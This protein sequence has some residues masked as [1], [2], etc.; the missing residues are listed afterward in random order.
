VTQTYGLVV[1]GASVAAEALISRLRELGDEREVLVVDADPRMPY[2]RPPLSKSYLVSPADTA[3]DVEWPPGVPVTVARAV[4]L[5]PVQRQLTVEV[6]AS[7]TT[8][9]VG[10]EQL[11]IATGA[12]PIH[13]PFEPDGVLALRTALDADQ[14]RAGAGVG[15]RIGIIGAG[16]IG[17]ELATSLRQ[18]GSEVVVLDKAAGPLE[19]LL[20]G[21]LAAEVTR[22][23]QES[24]IECRW[25]VDIAEISGSGGQWVVSLAD[26]DELRFDSLIS[27]IGA[28]PTIAWLAESGLLTEGQ[29]VCDEIG[30]VIVDG[31]PNDHI[32][33][34]GDVVTRLASDGS[35]SRTESWSAAAEQGAR[36]AEQLAGHTPGEP[37]MPYFWTDVAG[38]RVQV[39]GNLPR[40][41]ALTTEFE[42]PERDAVVYKVADSTGATGYIAVNAPAKIAMLRAAA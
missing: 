6:A 16:A 24:G 33:A 8:R 31:L 23:L 34:A 27:A 26:G 17:V 22:W 5:D 4:A 39:L 30:R 36:L 14:L 25:N 41:G 1:V 28:R 37:E 18:M 9:T 3:I 42:N 11:V 10:F 15:K 29:L 20:A 35:L 40:G 12:E 19:R 38:R 2:E 7:G 13:L 32:C 21:H